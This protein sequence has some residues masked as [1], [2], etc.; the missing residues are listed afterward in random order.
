VLESS[1]ARPHAQGDGPVLI[2]GTSRGIGNALA[3]QLLTQG[4][5]VYGVSRTLPTNLLGHPQ[6]AHLTVDLAQTGDLCDAVLEKLIRK[7]GIAR[8]GHV[9]LNAGQ[10]SP[11]IA[12]MNQVPLSEIQGLVDANV[13]ANK[14]LLDTL[15]GHGI[16]MGTC[17]VSSSIAGARARAGNSG[18][19]ISK[20]MLN[21]MM[22][23]YALE[24]PSTYFAVLGLCN[25]D[26]ALARRIG[27]LPLEGCFPEIEKLRTRGAAPGY[28]ATADDRAIHILRLLS[29]GLPE[30]LESGQFAEVRTLIAQPW[31]LASGL[32]TTRTKGVFQ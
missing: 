23:L 1:D 25:V 32:E 28:L 8:L 27:A 14:V 2:T 29:L 12:P 7:H 26:T 13:W 5:T 20:A 11:R 10:F 31:F 30:R 4:R 9:F 15:I 18:Y 16:A 19:A 6:Y 21:M 24:N 3:R 17:V 22:Q